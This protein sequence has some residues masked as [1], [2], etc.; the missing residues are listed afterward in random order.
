MQCFEKMQVL[1]FLWMQKNGILKYICRLVLL[2][3]REAR[4]TNLMAQGQGRVQ[5]ALQ[6]AF[7]FLLLVL[8]S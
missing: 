8:I 4:Q 5:T 1:I 3:Q 7:F 2:P 6:V